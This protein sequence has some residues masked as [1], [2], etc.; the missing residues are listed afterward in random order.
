[1]P[2]INPDQVDIPK[3]TRKDVLRQVFEMV[4]LPQTYD[5]LATL[6]R[7]TAAPYTGPFDHD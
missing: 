1:M 6:M 7:D 4:G 5:E 3:L 2:N